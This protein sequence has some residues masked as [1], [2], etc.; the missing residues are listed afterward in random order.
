MASTEA[1]LT[2]APKGLFGLSR[3]HT[4]LLWAAGTGWLFDAVFLL[5]AAIVII[6]GEETHGRTLEE[7]TGAQSPTAATW[8]S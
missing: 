5:I 3:F 1:T 8:A 4:P 2:N 6:L 7:I